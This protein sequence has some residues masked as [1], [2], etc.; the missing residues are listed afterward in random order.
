MLEPEIQSRLDHAVAIARR[1]GQLVMSYAKQAVAVERKSDDSPVTVADR[2]AEKQL[3]AEIERAFPDDSIV[4]E[5]HP[6]KEGTS[7]F[8]W[9][10]D[11]IDGTKTFIAGVPLFG[12]LVAVQRNEESVIGVIEIPAIDERVYAAIGGGAYWQIGDASPQR[13]QVASCERLADAL[14]VTTDVQSFAQRG[15]QAVHQQLADATW[16]S[17]TWG[18][19]Y[20]YFLV[21]TGRATVMVD[22]LMN[23][24]DAAA[25]LPVIT[26]AGG[27]F[28]DWSGAPR[29]DSGDSV[30]TN[31]KVA[32]EVLQI[33]R[34][35][36]K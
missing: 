36:A 13:T 4:G 31:G 3:R 8:R 28:T 6:P 24:W 2:E 9:I 11:P 1:A 34:Q 32:E 23:L 14:Y 15:A 27:T 19:C 12:T 16:Y 10:L 22:P 21:A 17:R 18:D 30:A 7:R 20:G 35:F 29:V 5:E 26:E 33:T 25:L